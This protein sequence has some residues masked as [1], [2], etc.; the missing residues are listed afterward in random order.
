ME[1]QNSINLAGLSYI[2]QLAESNDGTAAAGWAGLDGLG[3]RVMRVSLLQVVIQRG[4]GGRQPFRLAGRH[5]A[6]VR[7][8][9]EVPPP[10]ERVD[11]IVG[12]GRRDR[13][14]LI[15]A[16]DLPGRVHG[17]SVAQREGS[18]PHRWMYDV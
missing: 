2:S 5:V 17:T 12:A 9:R 14:Q 15:I 10:V 13:V 7:A 6:G 16:G 3:G 11:D 8:G 18:W 1:L 4:G